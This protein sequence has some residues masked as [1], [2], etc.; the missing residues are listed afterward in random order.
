MCQF[1]IFFLKNANLMCQFFI[2]KILV[3]CIFC[4]KNK[5]NNQWLWWISSINKCFLGWISFLNKYFL[6]I[7]VNDRIL[8]KVKRPNT[9]MIQIIW[10][11]KLFFLST[12]FFMFL[13]LI[14]RM[15][16]RLYFVLIIYQSNLTF[17]V[18]SNLEIF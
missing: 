6:Y 17:C 1:F 5:L 4:N 9:L 16:D 3:I 18:F 7:N 14:Q 8:T 15:I 11:K 12:I 2:I 10:C 13:N